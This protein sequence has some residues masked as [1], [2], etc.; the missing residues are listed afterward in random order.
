MKSIYIKALLVILTLWLGFN[1]LLFGF[2]NHVPAPWL[3][4]DMIGLSMGAIILIIINMDIN[5]SQMF[6]WLRPQNTAYPFDGKGDTMHYKK[7]ESTE[8]FHY[9]SNGHMIHYRE[10]C[11]PKEEFHYHP[12]G[13]LVTFK[14]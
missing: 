9:D 6:S 4:G 7:S 10:H 11:E 3:F 8:E 12:N 13:N 2:Y 1:A 5:F 14:K